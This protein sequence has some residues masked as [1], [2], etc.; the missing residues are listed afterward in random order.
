[1]AP[2]TDNRTAEVEYIRKRLADIEARMHQTKATP[3]WIVVLTGLV[4][5][6]L[7]FVAGALFAK[8]LM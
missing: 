8:Y 1:M 3:V 7:L 6:P 5:G 2:S 4:G